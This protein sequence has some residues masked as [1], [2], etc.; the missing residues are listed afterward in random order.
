MTISICSENLGDKAPR[1]PGY[2][3]ERH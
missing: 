1:P 3:Y 2:A